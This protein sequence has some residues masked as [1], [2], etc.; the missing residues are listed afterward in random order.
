MQEGFI[1][2]KQFAYFFNN[3]K[4]KHLSKS[5]KDLIYALYS[6]VNEDDFVL[7][8]SSKYLEKADIK[9]KINGIVKGVSIKTGQQCSMHQE[10]L[11][12]FNRFLLRIGVEENIISKFTKFIYGEINNKRVTTEQYISQFSNDIAEIKRSFNS[13]SNRFHLITRFLFHGTENQLY[14]CDA[15]IYG[16]PNDFY[17]ATKDEIL[18][19][20]INYP[21]TNVNFLNV[22]LLNV[23]CYDRNINYN[24]NRKNVEHKVQVKWFSLPRDIIYISKIRE[25]NLIKDSNNIS[26]FAKHLKSNI[27]FKEKTKKTAFK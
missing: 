9:I 23:R 13:Y 17:W 1:N 5:A 19:L 11:D 20:L 6:N 4:V 16:L 24:V 3:K 12:S 8:W 25:A 21:Y 18:K 15:I 26:C 14:D 2:E 22:S 7:C 10:S 27:E